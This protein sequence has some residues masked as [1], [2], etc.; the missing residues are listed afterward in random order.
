MLAEEMINHIDDVRWGLK[1]GYEI[2]NSV[3]AVGQHYRCRPHGNTFGDFVF[4][5]D[6]L[7]NINV[8]WRVGA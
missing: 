7:I 4:V 3:A 2:A 1:S 5:F 8:A 6:F